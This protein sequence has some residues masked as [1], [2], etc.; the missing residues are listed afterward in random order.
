MH[1]WHNLHP[2]LGAIA[3]AALSGLSLVAPLHAVADRPP[4]TSCPADDQFTVIAERHYTVAARVRPLLFWIRRDAVGDARLTW[5]AAP[6]GATRIELLIGSDPARTPMRINRWG[7]IAET[8]CGPTTTVVGLMSESDEQSVE[9]ARAGVAAGDGRNHAFKV[10]R[11]RIVAGE[12][13]AAV[14]R[15]VVDEDHTYR[16][17]D[18]LLRRVPEAMP[19]NRRLRADGIAEGFLAA[20]NALIRQGMHAGQGG[21]QGRAP[22]RPFL[23]GD[24]A[25]DVTLRSSRPVSDG[26]TAGA[27]TVLVES[28]FEVRN[29]A[30]GRV[31]RFHLVHGID[32]ALAG[33]P[34]RIAYRP[35]WWLELD[36]RLSAGNAGGAQS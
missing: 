29:R 25:F 7:Y 16:D 3:A 33:F 4:A 26:D 17:L 27:G 32:G 15:L 13:T 10:I 23:H 34:V 18:L 19:A 1:A 14:T 8:T 12:S 21:G 6:G 31:T 28:A 2:W 11:S 24:R 5:S 22:S 20:T 30:T 9:E 35:R 36:L